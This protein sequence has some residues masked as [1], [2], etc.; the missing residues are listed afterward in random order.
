VIES[1]YK[2]DSIVFSCFPLCRSRMTDPPRHVTCV[3]WP[4]TLSHRDT[5][6]GPS[7]HERHRSSEPRA[8]R[9]VVTRDEEEI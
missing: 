6:R 4:R 3:V 5:L 9:P 2:S 7:Q 1:G 8:V